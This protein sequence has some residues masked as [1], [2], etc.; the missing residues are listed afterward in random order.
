[1]HLRTDIR[2]GAV[3]CCTP[4]EDSAPVPFLPLPFFVPCKM[5]SREL[6]NLHEI[7]SITSGL[8][9]K[10]AHLLSESMRKIKEVKYTRKEQKERLNHDVHTIRTEIKKNE[11]EIKHLRNSL[12]KLERTLDRE[13]N[14][15]SDAQRENDSLYKQVAEHEENKK[16]LARLTSEIERRVL[17]LRAQR[18]NEM[19]STETNEKRLESGASQYRKALG[20]NIT[21]ICDNM[22]KIE[23]FN[24]D[25]TD[26][27]GY[28][29]MDF[30][31]DT[32][33]V[34]EVWPCVVSLEKINLV[35]NISDDFYDFLKRVRGIFHDS[36][37][38]DVCK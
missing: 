27:G 38:E 18:T 6:T 1:M 34:T 30:K 14:D 36:I 11:E 2:C 31:D 29:V 12:E 26:L 5:T 37:K 23:F 28:I 7:Q 33:S 21:Q 20:I 16:N 24:F 10:F 25:E 3:C 13:R 15:L 19:R 32:E 4:L 9:K 22:L 35:L 17:G 8:R